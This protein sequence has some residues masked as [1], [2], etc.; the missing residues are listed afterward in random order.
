MN[1][2]EHKMT[3]IV[4]QKKGDLPRQ[5]APLQDE[6][7]RGRYSYVGSSQW[8]TLA[9]PTTQQGGRPLD[10]DGLWGK[11]FTHAPGWFNAQEATEM[12]S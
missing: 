10:S 3:V 8:R 7:H 5:T 9:L 1:D 12:P 11:T 2:A 4:P 6:P